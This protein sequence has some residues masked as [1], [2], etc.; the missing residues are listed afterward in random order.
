MLR[1]TPGFAPLRAL[2]LA[3][4][5]LFAAA[6]AATAQ[7]QGQQQSAA[8]PFRPVA[9]VNGSAIT[10]FDLAQRAQ[11]MAALGFPAERR[12]ALRREALDRLI[13]DRLKLQ[14]ADRL[15]ISA[16]DEEIEAGIAELAG[17]GG[18]EADELLA[19]LSAEGISRQAVAD[20]VRADVVWREV[21]RTR[22]S[23]R[24]QPGEAEVESELELLEERA[25]VDYRIAE[26]GLPVQDAD[27]SPAE[28]RAL[29]DRLFQELSQGGDFESAVRR[30]S[31]APSAAE[32]GEVGWVSSSGMPPH[33]A[34][35]LEGLEPGDITRP[36]EV[37]GGYSILKVLD[38]RVRSAED[39]E[40][41][42]Q[43]REQVRS[44]LVSQEGARLAEGLL[45]ELRR[46]ALIEIR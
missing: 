4:L 16:T 45:Q 8:T 23:R 2:A 41:D 37:A 12:E 46:D 31:R 11:I 22:F 35:A 14:E 27:R 19:L 10:G 13:E 3:V 29:A 39:L 9:V 21:V 44:R 38:R 20:S 36:I 34:E 30:H 18:L 1:T 28:T 6:P 40:G 15:G 5:A 32:G 43:L 24:V 17:Q 25:G 26:I 42:E 33:I 7:D